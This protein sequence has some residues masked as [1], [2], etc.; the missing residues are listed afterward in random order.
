MTNEL[1]DVMEEQV[2]APDHN[3]NIKKVLVAVDLSP[4]S[5]RTAAY[6]AKLA[7]VFGASL[8]LINVCSPDRAAQVSNQKDQRFGEPMIAPEVELEQLAKR[9]RKI[10]PTCNA[11]L[12]VGDPAD[13]VAKVAE[14]LQADLIITASHHAGFL[15]RPIGLDHAQQ[16]LH[17][18]P[19]PVLVYQEPE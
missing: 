15:G 1:V 13:K 11:Y 17:R 4:H 14:I 16:I 9:V 7:R 8:T 6:A 19:C 10:Y 3:G 2:M 18:A 5:E 12:Y